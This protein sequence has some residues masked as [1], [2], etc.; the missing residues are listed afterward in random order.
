MP[1]LTIVILQYRPDAGALRR[2]L[3]ALAMQDTRDFAVVLGDDGS[4]QDY[5]AESRAYLA[6]H[7]ITD[8]QTVKLMPN[9][10]TVKN[11]QNA[12]RAVTSRWVLTLSPGDFLYDSE[13][14]RWWLGRLQ[15]DAPRV[16]FGRQAY[17]APGSDPHPVPGETPFDRTPYD[18]AHYDARTV[19]RNLLLYDDGISGAGLVYERA[20]LQTAMDTM[21]GRVRLAEDFSLRMFAVQGIQ[22]TRYDRLTVWYEYG[23]GVST[24]A[25]ARERMLGEWRAM[26]ALLREKFPRDLTVRLAY[27]YYFNDRRKSRLVRGLVGRLIVPQSAP[28]KKAQRAWTPPTNGDITILRAICAFAEKETQTP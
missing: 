27:E 24:D 8:V 3:A 12:L 14:L 19:R 22:I 18:P 4:P 20:L 9:G 23:G 26:L 17:F 28:F 21:A 25:R 5:F 11:M 6:A 1:Q 2:T 15:A 10:G 7:G 16:A 13:T